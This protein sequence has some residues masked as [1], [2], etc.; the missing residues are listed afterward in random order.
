MAHYWPTQPAPG[1]LG[2]SYDTVEPCIDLILLRI[3]GD[4]M[5]DGVPEI[6]ARFRGLMMLML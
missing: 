4:G 1:P 6:V 3:W 5:Q 2:P